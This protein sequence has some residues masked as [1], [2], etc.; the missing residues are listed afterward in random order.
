MAGI[1]VSG[2]TAWVLWSVVHI[3]YLV[4]FRNRLITMLNW[5]FTYLFF[6]KG[7]RLI[8]GAAARE[9]RC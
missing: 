8:T 5:I 2:L 7:S 4:G 3:A 1:R 6:S 9:A